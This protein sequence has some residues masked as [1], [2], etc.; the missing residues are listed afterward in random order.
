MKILIL[1]R[2][3]FSGASSRYRLYQYIPFLSEQGHEVFVKPLLGEDYIKYLYNNKMSLPFAEII[4]GYFQRIFILLNKNKYDII[5]LQQEAFPWIPSW[6]EKFFWESKPKLVTDYD[7]AF[8]HRYD[9]HKSQFVRSILGKKIDSIMSYAD[10]ILAGNEYL[11]ERAKKNNK[12]KNI[13]IFPTVVDINKFKFIEN[14]KD[15]IFTIGWIGTPSTEKY[16]YEIEDVIKEISKDR[17]VK[18]VLLGAN[19]INIESSILEIKKWEES[20]EIVEISKF[21]V[22]VMPLPDNPWERGKCGFK[23]IQYLACGIPVIGSPVGVNSKIIVD[24]ENGF[25]AK[26]SFEWINYIKTLKNDP[27]LRKKMSIAGRKLVEEKYSLQ[28]N[29]LKL[30][31]YFNTLVQE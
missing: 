30:I 11:A 10:L 2:Y 31:E 24:G 29:S 27:S 17:D 19:N 9:D 6:F 5:W 4:K 26:N 22:G 20:T 21:D 14:K 8:F 25:Q 7:D 23:L 1:P 16:I 3:D 18:F 28:N 15:S 12:E 13:K